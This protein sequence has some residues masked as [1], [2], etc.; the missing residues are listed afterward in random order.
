M[1]IQSSESI[2]C[3]DLRKEWAS[4]ICR[5]CEG[6]N[7]NWK[8]QKVGRNRRKAVCSWSVPSIGPLLWRERAHHQR[9]YD[10]YG[11]TPYCRGSKPHE[12]GRTNVPVVLSCPSLGSL[13]WDPPAYLFG[14]D[15][16]LSQGFLLTI[17]GSRF[18]EGYRPLFLERIRVN[19]E[20][21]SG[22]CNGRR[23]LLG[24]KYWDY[25]MRSSSVSRFYRFFCT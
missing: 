1:Y 19:A 5:E 12:D 6:T 9:W 3:L 24:R 10:A 16:F 23:R 13:M 25:S 7:G 11:D 2:F 8:M 4:R 20:F 22:L 15:T 14:M 21:V 17:G 18:R